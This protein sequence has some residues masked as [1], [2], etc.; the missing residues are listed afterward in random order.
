MSK[1]RGGQ[2]KHWAE[3]ARVWVWYYEIKRRCD[4]TDYKLDHEFAW[5]EEGKRTRS[6]T[7][8][9]RT[10][11]WI[12]K[13]AR[14]P[15]GRD[16]RWRGMSEL[17]ASVEQNPL[18][19]GTQRL[20]EFAL[21]HFLQERTIAPESLCRRLSQLM[22]NH[23]LVR[24]PYESMAPNMGS[25]TNE[26]GQAQVFD[27]CLR[28]TLGTMDKLS[29]I[30]LAWLMFQQCEF[31]HSWEFRKVIEAI[32]D[33]L[34]DH[35]FYDYLPDMHLVF[36]PDAIDCLLY[37]RLNMKFDESYG[38]LESEGTWPVLPKDLVGD[39][40]EKYLFGGIPPE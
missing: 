1:K 32:A 31:A 20:Y 33:Q 3:E 10:F 30:E 24:V 7:D 8:R 40:E 13:E 34:L 15:A 21:W 22:Q 9:P 6:S 23:N 11:E 39:I 17:V 2:P 12:R 25:L 14:K 18:F 4:W 36:Y 5:T 26:F 19:S 28:L 35:F 37:T 27:R 38:Y 16:A 29:Q